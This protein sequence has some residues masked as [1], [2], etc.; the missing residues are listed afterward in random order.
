MNWRQP[1]A[2]NGKKT[3]TLLTSHTTVNEK[4]T[5]ILKLSVTKSDRQIAVY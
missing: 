2:H 1:H 3:G 5:N 4:T